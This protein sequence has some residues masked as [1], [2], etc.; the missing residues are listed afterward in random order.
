MS[1][2]TN[3][4]TEQVN[5]TEYVPRPIGNTTFTTTRTIRVGGT[6]QILAIG[7]ISKV[8]SPIDNKGF[9]HNTH[10]DLNPPHPTQI[11]P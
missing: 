7:G 1:N 11:H 5:M 4:S 2:A 10:Q 6:T 8:L 9:S 3:D